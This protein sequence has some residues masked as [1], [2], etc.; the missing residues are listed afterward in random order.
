MS[1][2]YIDAAGRLVAASVHHAVSFFANAVGGAALR[3]KP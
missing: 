1:A 3:S 2:V